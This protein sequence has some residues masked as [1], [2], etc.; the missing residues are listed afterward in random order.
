MTSFPAKHQETLLM[1]TL[2]KL[3]AVK[4][5]HYLVTRFGPAPLRKIA[6]DEVYRSGRWDAL[7]RKS[8]AD[9]VQAVQT[10]ARGGRILDL[11]CGTG[12]LATS[13]PAGAYSEYLGVD[14]SAEA[15]ERAQAKANEKVH[16]ALADIEKYRPPHAFDLIVFQ[17]SLMYVNPLSRQQVLQSYREHLA[18]DGRFLVTVVQSARFAAML[19]MIRERFRIIEDRTLENSR[20][21]R[22]LVFTP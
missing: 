21:W 8:S 10:H 6:F 4:G 17:E 14:V 19:N 13:V 7:D 15:L 3:C 11:G 20:H 22:L 5:V 16:F 2:R 18:A 12:L 1:E 9:L